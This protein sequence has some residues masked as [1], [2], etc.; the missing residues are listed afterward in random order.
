MSLYNS[1]L[2][3]D[4]LPTFLFIKS[5]DFTVTRNSSKIESFQLNAFL[6]L[7]LRVSIA[8]Y[9]LFCTIYRWTFFSLLYL[10]LL[11]YFTGEESNTMR[12]V[13]INI[14][15]R[16]KH[17]R[18][19]M[20]TERIQ[21]VAMPNPRI[22][23]VYRMLAW[24]MIAMLV[25]TFMTYIGYSRQMN[26]QD[27]TLR[28]QMIID[29]G[30]STDSQGFGFFT[31]MLNLRDE[32][33]LSGLLTVILIISKTKLVIYKHHLNVLK[34]FY[35]NTVRNI[36]VFLLVIGTVAIPILKNSPLTVLPAFGLGGGM[37]MVRLD[38]KSKDRVKSLCVI[39]SAWFMWILCISTWLFIFCNIKYLSMWSTR[40]SKFTMY[41]T[42]ASENSIECIY[43]Q[44]MVACSFLVYFCFKVIC[45]CRAMDSLLKKIKFDT[46]PSVKY[47]Q[48]HQEDREF[49]EYISERFSDI[50]NVDIAELV[51][52]R[53][54]WRDQDYVENFKEM[55]NLDDF[56]K[57]C[58]KL[59]KSKKKSLLSKVIGYGKR[60]IRMALFFISKTIF[61]LLFG[62]F[63]IFENP[64]MTYISELMLA[65]FYVAIV[66]YSFVINP[67]IAWIFLSMSGWVGL[68]SKMFIILKMSTLGIF[69]CVSV[70][71][72]KLGF[73]STVESLTNADFNFVNTGL[74]RSGYSLIGVSLIFVL[75]M[76]LV[77]WI[78]FNSNN[79]DSTSQSKSF[80]IRNSLIEDQKSS[81]ETVNT[82]AQVLLDL[83]LGNIIYL[84]LINLYLVVINV[85]IANIIL[86][87]F[88]LWVVVSAQVSKRQIN[89][90]LIFND[91]IIF[92]RYN[93]NYLIEN[94][95]ITIPDSVSP[96]ISLL[97]LKNETVF[98]IDNPK[99][100]LGL[101]ISLNVFIIMF[102]LS[103]K[104]DEVF[105]MSEKSSAADG[106]TP[107]RKANTGLYHLLKSTYDFSRFVVFYG[108]PWFAYTMITIQI[109]YVPCNT[110]SI[111]Q[112]LFTSIVY[113]RHI[114]KLIKIDFGGMAELKS[115]WRIL[116]AVSVFKVVLR[117][118]IWVI[119]K[120]FFQEKFTIIGSL[121]QLMQKYTAISDF[122]GIVLS[123][124]S[125]LYLEMLPEFVTMFFGAGF[126]W[127]VGMIEYY[128]AN[129]E[130]IDKIKIDSSIIRRNSIYTGNEQNGQNKAEI[131]QEDDMIDQIKIPEQ[132]SNSS[133]RRDSENI[134]RSKN[135]SEM[136]NRVNKNI[137]C[138][139]IV[140]GDIA[141]FKG[142]RTS[143][144]YY[145]LLKLI[146]GL[147]FMVTVFFST[148]FKISIGMAIVLGIWLNF[149]WSYHTQFWDNVQK[150]NINEK[151]KRSL[152]R[153]YNIYLSKTG[154]MSSVTK[155][156][157]EKQSRDASLFFTESAELRKLE[158]TLRTSMCSSQ[159]LVL[160]I[161][162][163]LQ[164]ISYGMPRFINAIGSPQ[165]ESWITYIF[166]Y[167]GLLGYS[168]QK[169]FDV[170]GFHIILFFVIFER[171]F[172]RLAKE[173]LLE[174]TQLEEKAEELS[175]S[176]SVL[177][178]NRGIIDMLRNNNSRTV[179]IEPYK[180]DMIV[181]DIKYSVSDTKMGFN[182][183]ERFKF[184]AEVSDER[185]GV[186]SRNML[187]IAESTEEEDSAR[188]RLA[189]LLFY[190][191]NKSLY[192]RC[193]VYFGTTLFL[194]RM[195]FWV[196][197][198]VY[199]S[200]E[201][202]LSMFLLI[203]IGLCWIWGM[204]NSHLSVKYVNRGLIIF[205]ILKYMLTIADIRDDLFHGQEPPLRRSLI[206]K[207]SSETGNT[208]KIFRQLN[209]DS[210]TMFWFVL[211]CSFFLIIQI[212]IYV[213]EEIMKANSI[214]IKRRVKEMQYMLKNRLHIGS[215]NF[216]IN[217]NFNAWRPASF[218]I[219][220]EI[221]RLTTIYLPIFIV[222]LIA[223]SQTFMNTVMTLVV[224]GCFWFLYILV[225]KWLFMFTAK[226]DKL[227]TASIW[228]QTAVWIYFFYESVWRNIF[229]P[230][231][232][233]NNLYPITI[234][235]A[236]GLIAFQLTRDLWK[237]SEFKKLY[238]NIIQNSKLRKLLIPQA[239][240]YHYNFNKLKQI[241]EKLKKKEQLDF[242]IEIMEK[243]LRIWH[244]RFTKSN[245]D[246]LLDENRQAETLRNM[247]RWEKEI[248]DLNAEEE[249]IM[250]EI[251]E[252]D[253]LLAS[254]GFVDKI[255]IKIQ[256][257]LIESSDMVE[258]DNNLNLI[259]TIHRSNRIIAK[260]LSQ[261]E[262]TRTMNSEA[263]L[264]NYITDNINDSYRAIKEILLYYKDPRIMAGLN[265]EEI[266]RSI[267]EQE[268]QIEI[269][270]RRNH[271]V[272]ENP[273]YS[274]DIQ[275][276]VDI[277][278]NSIVAKENKDSEDHEQHLDEDIQTL[279]MVTCKEEVVFY[280]MGQYTQVALGYMHKASKTEAM[281]TI[282]GSIPPLIYS[283]WK[284]VALFSV[285]VACLFKTSILKLPLL[286][287]VIMFG[288]T[289]EINLGRKFWSFV[290]IYIAVLICMK[291]A[292]R[293]FFK[294]NPLDYVQNSEFIAVSLGDRITPYIQMICGDISFDP[295]EIVAL[296]CV[297]VRII[298]AQKNGLFNHFVLEDENV[299]QAFVRLEQN[300]SKLEMW[301]M[302]SSKEDIYN[303]ILRKKKDLN[304]SQIKS[305]TISLERKNDGLSK[306]EIEEIHR[307]IVRYNRE[308]RDYLSFETVFE[309][310]KNYF[311][312][313]M[314]KF[315]Q[316]RVTNTR[317]RLFS[318]HM[319]K[320]GINLF[321][322]ITLLQIIIA[323]YIFLL[324][325]TME[326]T[327]EGVF[328]S[329]KNSQFSG[330]MIVVLLIQIFCIVYERYIFLINP[331]D[332]RNW[333]MFRRISKDKTGE[334]PAAP[335]KEYQKTI[336]DFK[337]NP[338]HTKFK[339]MILVMTIF[340]TLIYII[341]PM[342]GNK[343]TSNDLVCN[344]LYMSQ[345]IKKG[346]N[347]PDENIFL[348][349]FLIL[350]TLY[351]VLS[352]FQI[353]YGETFLKNQRKTDR[354]WSMVDKFTNLIVTK[355]LYIFEIKVALDFSV[356]NTSLG[357]FE[358]FKLEDTF[359]NFFKAKYSQIA[360]DKRALGQPQGLSSKLLFGWVMLSVLLLILFGP[361][362]MFSNFNPASSGNII[363]A[364]Q[365]DIGV[366]IGDVQFP[367]FHNSHHKS[368]KVL[369]TTEYIQY[370]GSNNAM[371][372][373]NPES[374]MLV[375]MYPFSDNTWEVTEPMYNTFSAQLYQALLESNNKTKIFTKF[376]FEQ[377][378]GKSVLNTS[379][380]IKGQQILDIHELLTKCNGNK[381]SVPKMN[382]L[383]R[384]A[385]N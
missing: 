358:W 190:H 215:K 271:Y 29:A 154:L 109:I 197:L 226:M 189:K 132:L 17:E 7:L 367:L 73:F 151:I 79:T 37:F 201:S 207:A 57:T 28:L 168:S 361:L 31:L 88:F 36:A 5:M 274:T 250:N 131:I 150:E 227:L 299:N 139:K 162:I 245:P 98:E 55:I 186:L 26:I 110:M 165:I 212:L 318:K 247:D 300:S 24:I 273:H 114:G 173:K 352:A 191:Q 178:Y 27:D 301:E 346:C 127:R 341:L 54:N 203:Y 260:K 368:L 295:A 15:K 261:G 133:I 106:Q 65:S 314:L 45:E 232:G 194:S 116:V 75:L 8:L 375:E 383:V 92:L 160:I 243:Q 338:M 14:K 362:Y 146:S 159:S 323:L 33:I 103:L 20:D 253:K 378:S 282:L 331:P 6:V 61:L 254:V 233:F 294:I 366:Q 16:L 240:A 169:I 356:S 97:G 335:M 158:I 272:E 95:L 329:L 252:E 143:N 290:Y 199:D 18:G 385:D 239:K 249:D 171:H 38:S 135:Q 308:R 115:A 68:D 170:Y 44:S 230:F 126:Q 219:F 128:I 58:I 228:L 49:K 56:Q 350:Y 91:I 108:F 370:F 208:Y 144:Y 42:N 46:K 192:L 59:R 210:M 237:S 129:R 225:F 30:I 188:S 118:I 107:K 235:T 148:Y 13:L 244:Q 222:L 19:K 258:F 248:A 238:N 136:I 52:D 206:L 382:Y 184:E 117:Y 40:I 72:T 220:E 217:I 196:L 373:F 96:L 319:R 122:I 86:L 76:E 93:Y 265:I 277:L 327:A 48:D 379:V 25:K 175:Q 62:L 105:N 242:R 12:L 140:K 285:I 35:S 155:E 359:N 11:F 200:K 134:E 142:K 193:Q 306:N 120:R 304:S 324:F 257:W 381:I 267:N 147:G 2:I 275:A 21:Y 124:N 307:L 311:R 339:F 123:H 209:N 161:F 153:F 119:F 264:H 355:A 325:Q 172:L 83:V 332:W 263:N 241:F 256:L 330:F 66:D 85:N 364:V 376:T 137:Y 345:L 348:K 298:M 141:F 221:L 164:Y 320:G 218:E 333:E 80:S 354:R 174:E 296:F 71:S 236:T 372:N 1:N 130:R 166:Y 328:E 185:R 286:I 187:T 211:E 102:K 84:V 156:E 22:L 344:S 205:I 195:A 292:L 302:F 336:N 229:Y 337:S 3:S 213:Y 99:L 309:S 281:M 81:K 32:L 384:S 310:T 353:K 315:P 4:K 276:G 82:V 53:G 343:S 63:K 326:M 9:L 23:H 181:G 87:G 74:Y 69:T 179:T 43:S 214:G 347:Y 138:K 39:Y 183:E 50:F 10:W 313:Y 113:F 112:L 365:M 223:G 67:I 255:L 270:N 305:N 259:F 149:Y 234:P 334:Q 269:I 202:L 198:Y 60:G 283:Q 167:M 163:F 293:T 377:L 303:D 246:M 312:Y 321:T 121:Y 287:Y 380:E 266:K 89:M 288:L 47:A 204:D 360:G 374:I 157:E 101:N 322:I 145:S 51:T 77:F 125:N 41:M 371:T 291:F 363:T 180:E 64:F 100:Y 111:L 316:K 351:F 289:E 216:P 278:F 251:D 224:I 262:G 340:Y 94:K 70:F 317:W 104:G 78:F 349:I 342:L 357:L 231:L 177:E 279:K 369:N 34:A 90:M 284:F 297:I 176:A 182:T 268:E 280:N 152:D